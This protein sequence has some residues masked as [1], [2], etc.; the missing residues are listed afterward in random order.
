MQSYSTKVG[1]RMPD[2]N[3]IHLPSSLSKESVYAMYVLDVDEPLSSTQFRIWKEK[4]SN[5]KITKVC[6]II[7]I[8]TESDSL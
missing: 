6:T 1:D 7:F 8:C 5:V 3:A 4:F 2:T